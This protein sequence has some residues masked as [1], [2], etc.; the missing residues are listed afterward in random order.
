MFAVPGSTPVPGVL[1]GVPPD[2]NLANCTIPGNSSPRVDAPRQ[3]V[4]ACDHV[5]ADVSRSRMRPCSRELRGS[6]GAA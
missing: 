5:A 6:R 1:S 3:V 2:T 4:P